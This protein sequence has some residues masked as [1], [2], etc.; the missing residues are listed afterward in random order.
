MESG[1]IDKKE[2]MVLLYIPPET[3]QRNKLQVKLLSSNAKLPKQ[4]KE[5]DV[6]YDLH[7]AESVIIE[8]RTHKLIKTDIAIKMPVGVYGRVAERSGLA[9]K[10]LAI[11]GGIIDPS[12]RGNI[13]II[14]RNLTEK[15]FKI[16]MGDRI[17]QLILERYDTPEVIE[18]NTLDETERGDKGFGSTGK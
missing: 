7:S 2:D 3:K 13:G 8:P 14:L 11:G 15:E 10:G 17:A 1:S 12:Y 5:G 16:D 18:V 4:P 6:G 9:L